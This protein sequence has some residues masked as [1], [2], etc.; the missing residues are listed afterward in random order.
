MGAQGSY[1]SYT[2]AK[3]L[4]Q[5]HA[6]AHLFICIGKNISIK[7][8]LETIQY[9]Q[10]ITPHIIEYTLRIPDLM[11]IADLLI[12]KSGSLTVAEALYSKL[13]MLVDQTSA[14]LSWEYFNHVLIETYGYGKT[15]KKIKDIAPMTTEI[16]THKT[17]Y[18]EIKSNL[19]HIKRDH[20]KNIEDL[21]A[22]I[23]Q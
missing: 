10:F 7:E 3:A 16:L 20:G 19:E 21:I 5:I 15:I 1:A 18:N 22:H 4:T 8:K 6:P 2:F 9:P 23:L 13:P 12:T 11:A 17:L 14:V